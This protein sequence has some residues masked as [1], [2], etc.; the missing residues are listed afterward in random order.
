MRLS[1]LQLDGNLRE[2]GEQYA[3]TEGMLIGIMDLVFESAGKIVLVDYKT[4]RVSDASAL[5]ERYT[6]QLRLYAQALKLLRGKPV[7]ECWL[8]SF[9]LQKA[10]PVSL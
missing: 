4:D 9:T 8:Y 5:L 2:L 3:G 1:D 6:E 7:A 10:I